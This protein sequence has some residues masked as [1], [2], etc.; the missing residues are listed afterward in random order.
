M[1]AFTTFTE[2]ERILLVEFHSNCKAVWIQGLRW[3]INRI[4]T[5]Q[6]RSG[7]ILVPAGVICSTTAV[8]R[9]PIYDR[10][11]NH[12]YVSSSVQAVQL[13]SLNPCL[14]AFSSITNFIFRTRRTVGFTLRSQQLVRHCF[15]SFA[16]PLQLDVIMNR[17][18]PIS[19]IYPLGCC[20]KW[21]CRSVVICAA[22]A[23][24]VIV[25]KA[26]QWYQISSQTEYQIF[27][28]SSAYELHGFCPFFAF[29]ADF[30]KPYPDNWYPVQY[31]HQIGIP[32]AWMKVNPA[33]NITFIPSSIR[34]I[35]PDL[36]WPNW[37]VVTTFPLWKYISTLRW[38]YA[39]SYGFCTAT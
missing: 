34:V 8:L 26:S 29:N 22:E 12:H 24:E 17:H 13:Q 20:I 18:H 15:P 31:W 19:T 35:S 33:M 6:T 7:A 3:I 11:Q 36:G 2:Q 28:I 30:I 21:T 16:R 5:G 23:S 39:I 1:I 25:W 4:F 32:T 37:S 10:H 27:L 38:A 14:R 9:L